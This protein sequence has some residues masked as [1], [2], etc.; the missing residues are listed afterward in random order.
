L[1]IGHGS[2]GAV[3]EKLERDGLSAVA[4][5]GGAGWNHEGGDGAIRAQR[6]LGAGDR[7]AGLREHEIARR[8]EFLP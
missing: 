4:I 8:E 3:D 5:R 7:R 1:A 6:T 2:V